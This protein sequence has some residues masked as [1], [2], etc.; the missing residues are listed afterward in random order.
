M[1]AAPNGVAGLTYGAGSHPSWVCRHFGT[2]S[3]IPRNYTF[4]THLLSGSSRSLRVLRQLAMGA[5]PATAN[6][7]GS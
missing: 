4:F 1:T 7:S 6:T 3:G 5:I 2:I